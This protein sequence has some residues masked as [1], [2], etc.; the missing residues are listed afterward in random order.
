[1]IDNTDNRMSEYLYKLPTALQS[2]GWTIQKYFKDEGFDMPVFRWIQTTLQMPAFQHLCFGFKNLVY[3]VLIVILKSDRSLMFDEKDVRNQLRECKA[4]NLIPCIIMLNDNT[5]RPVLQSF[6]F[7]LMSTYKLIANAKEQPVK[8]GFFNTA[9]D[10]EMS[11]WEINSFGIQVVRDDVEKSGGKIL[12]YSDVISVHPNIWFEKEGRR[13]M[14]F[15]EVHAGTQFNTEPVVMSPKSK[16]KLRIYDCYKAEV[17]LGWDW[18]DEHRK[19][20][21]GEPSYVS[22][23]GLKKISIDD[24]PD[25]ES[26]EVRSSD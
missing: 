2:A 9:E 13:A 19:L 25:G 18:T 10:V 26:F 5:F 3:S 20:M 22:Y 12:S 23:P 4:N 24:I 15:V 8:P 6:S 11:P 17:K 21:R 1:M 7:P 14:V 16:A